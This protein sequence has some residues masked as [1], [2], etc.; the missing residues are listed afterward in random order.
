MPS[1]ATLAAR[2]FLSANP[3]A[4]RPS[5]ATPNGSA[6]VPTNS[7]SVPTGSAAVPAKPASTPTT[8]TSVPPA[9]TSTPTTGKAT[10]K[11]DDLTGSR[12]KM[13][14][15]M[16]SPEMRKIEQQMRLD[17]RKNDAQR[18]QLRR[19]F[20]RMLPKRPPLP[21]QSAESLK[22]DIQSLEREL[23]MKKSRLEA[24]KTREAKHGPPPEVKKPALSPTHQ[25][26]LD[27]M[28]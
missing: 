8:S 10:Q 26:V 9:K 7:V 2:S 24:A 1:P 15:M 22:N 5:T 4:S 23:Q 3:P 20:E 25:K 11:R 17:R 21:P 28:K 18:H 14:Q 12:M 16:Q 27:L 19:D 6:S 13:L